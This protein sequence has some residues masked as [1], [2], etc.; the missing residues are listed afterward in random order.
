MPISAAKAQNIVLS[1]PVPNLPLPK[2]IAKTSPSGASMNSQRSGVPLSVI[3]MP[4]RAI[5]TDC[6]EYLED[7][8]RFSVAQIEELGFDAFWKRHQAIRAALETY[9]TSNGYA[10][11]ALFVTDLADQPPLAPV[12]TL[13]WG[14]GMLGTVATTAA[15]VVAGSFLFQGIESLMGHHGNNAGLLSGNNPAPSTNHAPP[16]SLVANHVPDVSPPLSDLDALGPDTDGS[17]WTQ[18]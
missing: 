1:V 15:G 13:G 6:K 16:E 14:S 8:R 2:L 3:A 18:G 7:G 17:D 10:F 11:S 9:R 4:E 5:T 12:A